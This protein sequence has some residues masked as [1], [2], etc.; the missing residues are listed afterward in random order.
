MSKWVTKPLEEILTQHK[1]APVTPSAE[2]LVLFAGVRWYGS[3]LFIREERLGSEVIGKCFPLKPGALVYN[4]LFAWKQAF[5]VV[6]EEYE[7]VVVSNEFPQFDVDT[8]QATPEFVALYCAS[9]QFADLARS[10]STGAA[11]VSRNRLKEIDLLTLP[12]K[13]PPVDQQRTITDLMSRVVAAYESA[14]QEKQALMRVLRLRRAQLIAGVDS[15]PVRADEAF[16]IRLGRQRSPERATGPSMTPYLR[17][18]NVGYDELRMDDVLSM[19]FTPTERERYQLEDGD[20]LVSEGSASPTAVGM[21]AVWHGEI[22][23]PVCFQNTLLRFRSVA[24]VTTP[25]FVR[26]WCLWAFEAGKFRDA[27]GEAPGV[28]H[29]GFKRASAMRVRLPDLGRQSE[30]AAILG[31]MSD[32]VA[33]LRTEA[34]R[35]LALRDALLNSLLTGEIELSEQL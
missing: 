5:A 23:G 13:L 32:A 2:D 21:P 28:R 33:S 3:G 7:G 8:D 4:R 31:P 24:G 18:A 16:E 25:E 19:D 11:A 22:E 6:G 1:P 15:E 17:S 14:E 12:I 30:V 29:I 9:P 35:L 27:A 34:E 26:H 20:V 10:L